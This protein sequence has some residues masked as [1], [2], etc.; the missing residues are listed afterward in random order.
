MSPAYAYDY[1]ALVTQFCQAR[2]NG[3][4]DEACA[5][6]KELSATL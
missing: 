1:N 3:K 2:Q 4:H 5:V 6:A